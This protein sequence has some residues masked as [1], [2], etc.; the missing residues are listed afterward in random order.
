[1]FEEIIKQQKKQIR[2]LHIFLGVL[3]FILHN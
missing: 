1:M 2:L 3:A